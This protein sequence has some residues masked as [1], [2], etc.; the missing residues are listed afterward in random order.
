[1]VIAAEGQPDIVVVG[2]GILGLSTAFQLQQRGYSVL[3]MDRK[4]PVAEAS[5]GNAGAFAFSEIIPLA[6]PGIMRQ[7]PRW[8]LDP[9]G[10]LSIPPKY[11][12]Q[13][14]PWMIRF[15][16]ACRP[17]RVEH[18]I[19][20]QTELMEH[21]KHAL[22]PFLKKTGTG[23]MLR[24]DGNL[25][26]YESR[27]EFEASLPFWDARERCNIP[28]EHVHGSY[29]ISE[30]QPGLDKR[31]VAA[32][33][34][35]EWYSITDPL[36]YALTIADIFRHRG[37]RIEVAEAIAVSGTEKGA[38]VTCSDGQV[39]SADKIVICAGA[40]SH[41]LARTI[42]DKIPLETERGYNTTLPVES[43][44]LQMQL[45]FGGHGFVVSKL[46]SGIRVGGAVE[47]AGLA[48][49]PNF[50]RAEA[51]MDKAKA[52]LPDLKTEGGSQWMG[53]RPSLPDTLPVI[54]KSKRSDNVIYAFGHGHLGLT[55][56]AGTAELVGQLID[57]EKPSIDLTSFRSDR[58]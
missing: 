32:T 15:W 1:M 38:E 56:S 39:I 14:A 3:V 40:W 44:D 42:G 25:Q 47:L 11:A 43:F 50:R 4:G 22:L 5:R 16:L 18:G 20:A 58:F 34:T 23:G 48:L 29:A 51:L 57:G 7:A 24:R 35:P 55:Q 19:Q 2:A 54:G 26:L 8:L 13:L 10:P 28:F 31:F 49:P 17:Q 37:G 46:S 21:S 12:L 41:K 36:E 30:Y 33:Y 53:F 45:T 52:F 27:A 9:L 6:T